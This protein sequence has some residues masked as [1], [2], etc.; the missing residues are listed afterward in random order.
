M[1]PN[2]NN[3]TF[4]S[5]RSDFLPVSFLHTLSLFVLQPAEGEQVES[6]LDCGLIK[7]HAYGVTALKK[8]RM[9]ETLNGMCN[10]TRLHMVRMRN[11]WG[12][13]DWTGVWSLG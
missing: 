12:T 4:R 3:D 7:G 6:V 13:A 2:C 1:C 10:A 9:S 5:H 11:P 8:L